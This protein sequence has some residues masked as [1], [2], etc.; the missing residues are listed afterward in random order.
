MAPWPVGAFVGPTSQTSRLYEIATRYRD[1]EQP[2]ALPPS[3]KQI[4]AMGTLLKQGRKRAGESCMICSW[5][6]KRCPAEL[7]KLCV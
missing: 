4:S 1:S 7:G 6:R 2:T 3:S 5:I